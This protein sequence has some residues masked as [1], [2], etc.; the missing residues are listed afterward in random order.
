MVEGETWID[1]AANYDGQIRTG[2]FFDGDFTGTGL[3][4]RGFENT[5]RRDGSADGLR[6][7]AW[8]C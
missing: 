6:V 5:F 3:R 7:A 2:R 1:A 8:I 4:L